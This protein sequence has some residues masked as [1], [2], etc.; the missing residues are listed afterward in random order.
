MEKKK[1]NLAIVVHSPNEAV[2]DCKRQSH[3]V[4]YITYY[5]DAF[6]SERLDVGAPGG[7]G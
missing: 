3:L 6:G 5:L 4:V 1:Q 2:G 7:K